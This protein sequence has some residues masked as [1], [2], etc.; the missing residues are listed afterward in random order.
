MKCPKCDYELSELVLGGSKV[1]HC[2]RCG[3]IWFD[4]DELSA[5]KD[6]RD[7][8]LSW[9][10]YDLWS[11][12]DQLQPSGSS[13]ECPRDRQPLFKIK[14]GPS[15][16]LVDVC[17]ECHG[18]WLDKDELD[19]ILAELKEKVTTETIP[20]Y[21]RDLETQVK[22]LVV[23]PGH[24]KEELRNIAIIMKLIEYR[25]AAEH[26]TLAKITSSLPD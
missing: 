26:P 25:L 17:M 2:G 18:V 10:E 13:V 21:L 11:D 24:T 1:H 16:V 12:K 14:Y 19:K 4:K 22:D 5:V 23:D 15:D 7:Q 3:G 9:L 20:E 6:E 8:D